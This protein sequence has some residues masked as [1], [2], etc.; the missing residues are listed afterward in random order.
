MQPGRGEECAA[1]AEHSG[2][3]GGA[4]SLPSMKPMFPTTSTGVT[5][6]SFDIGT[7]P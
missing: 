5:T 3:G 1:G 2:R 6:S 4:H 7:Y